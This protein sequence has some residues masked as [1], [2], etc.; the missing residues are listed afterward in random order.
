VRDASILH[1]DDEVEITL[2]QGTVNA[3]I[4]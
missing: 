4:Q 3:K 1:T 2:E